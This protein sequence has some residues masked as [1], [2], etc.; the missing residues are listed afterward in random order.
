[1]SGVSSRLFS[2]IDKDCLRVS[3]LD[4]R[5]VVATAKSHFWAKS[6][7]TTVD[8]ATC[9]AVPASVFSLVNFMPAFV[10]RVEA[11]V[12]GRRVFTIPLRIRLFRTSSRLSISEV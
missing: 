9:E 1:M 5:F 7:F 2:L 11:G 4:K 3:P 12:P 10:S 8:F 6:D